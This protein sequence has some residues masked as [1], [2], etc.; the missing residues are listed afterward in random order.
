MSYNYYRR[1]QRNKRELLS[2]LNTYSSD[3][4]HRNKSTNDSDNINV[5]MSD[6]EVCTANEMPY[7]SAKSSS[8]AIDVEYTDRFDNDYGYISSPQSRD[9]DTDDYLTDSE[10]LVDLLALW[11]NKS[12]CTRGCTND[13]LKILRERGH[14][15]PKDC[16]TLLSTARVVDYNEKCG[17]IP[18]YLGIKN[19]IINAMESFE[20][21]VLLDVN[22][23]SLPLSKSFKL[24]FWPIHGPFFESN[25]FAIA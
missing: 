14:Y 7:S 18:V 12:N 9:S 10:S 2:I 4:N 1:Y 3:E 23:D 17:G 8:S 24:Q 13:L 5:S 20:Q 6:T 11:V 22:I 19:S 21:E 15:L 25:V 16:R